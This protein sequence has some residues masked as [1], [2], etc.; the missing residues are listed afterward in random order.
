MRG[1]FNQSEPVESRHNGQHMSA[2]GW[3]FQTLRESWLY[4]PSV[5]SRALYRRAI[6]EPPYF[7]IVAWRF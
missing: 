3:Q 2:V 4:N 5:N 6:G 7:V 1:Q